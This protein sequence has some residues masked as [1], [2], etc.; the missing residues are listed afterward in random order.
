MTDTNQDPHQIETRIKLVKFFSQLGIDGAKV[1]NA[2]GV[3]Q[4]VILMDMLK[5]KTAVG[6][7]APF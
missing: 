6:C 3:G 1:I 7:E 2:Y 5:D 4:S